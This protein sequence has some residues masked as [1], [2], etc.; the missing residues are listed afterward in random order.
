MIDVFKRSNFTSDSNALAVDV[1]GELG[2]MWT[3]LGNASEAQV[4]SDAAEEITAVL[5]ARLWSDDHFVTQL[6]TDGTFFDKVDYDSN[7]LATAFVNMT[8]ARLHAVLKR[9]DSGVCTHAGVGTYISE[10]L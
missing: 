7:L 1:L 9:V 2:E 8:D 5:N 4:Y 6:N 10:Q 3:F